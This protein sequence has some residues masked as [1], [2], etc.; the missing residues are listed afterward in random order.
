MPRNPLRESLET[1]RFCHVVEIVA[2]AHFARSPASRSGV[3]VG[4]HTGSRGWQHHQ[5]CRRIRRSGPAPRWYRSEGARSYSEHSRDMCQPGPPPA[6]RFS[7]RY[8]RH[9]SRECFR[10]D[11]RLS[12]RRSIGF[13]HGFGRAG[14]LDESSCGS[15]K[16]GRS[17][18]VS[19]F[20][21]LNTPNPI[22]HISTSSSKR[23]SPPAPITPLLSLAS[24]HVNSRSL[25][26]TS[27]TTGLK[28]LFSAT[29][30]YW[31]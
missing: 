14:F 10:P 12:E 5:L 2:S 1:G 3:A 17:G 23:N 13:R 19:P 22:A 21:R 16:A 25:S 9:R 31:D 18:S 6:T 27:M 11:W 29:S 24:M 30:T 4:R 26:A 8:R 15:E 7:G 20:H 28:S